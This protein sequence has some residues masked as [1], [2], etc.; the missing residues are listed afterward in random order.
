MSK[1][2]QFYRYTEHGSGTQS[3]VVWTIRAG[4][5]GRGKILARCRYWDNARAYEAAERSMTQQLR[6]AGLSWDD[7]AV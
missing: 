4:A 1:A 7:V 3:E 6:A 5:K 2:K